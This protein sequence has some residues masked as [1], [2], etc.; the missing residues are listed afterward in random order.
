MVIGTFQQD[1]IAKPVTQPQVDANRRKDIRQKLL[2]N[3]M[4]RYSLHRPSNKKPPIC[5]G[6][7]VCLK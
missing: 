3:C 1:R 6:A 4:D 5:S 2:T 7:L